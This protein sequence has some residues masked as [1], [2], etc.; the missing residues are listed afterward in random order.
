[1]YRNA[2][3]EILAQ[4]NARIDN[5]PYLLLETVIAGR[6]IF[7][8][9]YRNDD[10]LFKALRGTP[11]FDAA[12]LEKDSVFVLYSVLSLCCIVFW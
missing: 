4:R 7:R 12:D 3:N 9:F 1:M 2:S 10:D 6:L 5:R 11:L 8:Q